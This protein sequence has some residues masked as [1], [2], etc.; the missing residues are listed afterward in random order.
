MI[1]MKIQKFLFLLILM[2]RFVVFS[3]T[4]NSYRPEREKIHDLVH[5]KLKVDFDFRSEERL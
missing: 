3:Q 5:T 1:F 4:Y 2:F